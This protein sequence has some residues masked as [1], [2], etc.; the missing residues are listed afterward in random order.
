MNIFI[1]GEIVMKKSYLLRKSSF[2]LASVAV[3]TLFAGT[4]LVAA[5]ETAPS[6][7]AA[8]PAE[9]TTA[10]T[11]TPITS[12][13]TEIATKASTP[14]VAVENAQVGDVI[15]LEVNT[16]DPAIVAEESNADGTESTAT[17][18][19]TATVKTTTLAE[20]DA[21]PGVS[22]P[23]TTT[24]TATQTEETDQYVTTTTETVNK[25]TTV[26]VVREADVVNRQEIQSTSDIVFVIDKSA[27]MDSHINDVANNIEKFVRDLSAKNITAR[28]GL[29]DYE[30]NDNVTYHDFAGSKFTNDTEAF[31]AALRTIRT[32][33]GW[34]E[35]TTP[36]THIATSPDYTWGTGQNNRRFAF[37]VTDEDIDISRNSPSKETALQALQNAGISLTV[38]G[39]IDDKAD[40]DPLV[41]GTNGLYLDI[42]NDFADSL[43]TQ[44]SNLVVETVQEGRVYRIQTDVY[45]MI[46]TTHVVTKPQAETS[47]DPGQPTPI[48]PAQNY[49]VQGAVYQAPTPLTPTHS[50]LPMTGSNDSAG[51]IALGLISMAF[52]L[53]MARKTKNN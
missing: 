17:A 41:N 42:E 9:A 11:A 52:G 18:T 30:R 23:M 45:E 53:G 29:V 2:G 31:I 12:A 6:A 26:E 16:T 5:D 35:A 24:Q 47:A 48:V 34:E 19:A 38:V 20:R 28:L 1:K 21:Q 40:F 25:T 39:E 33:G 50:E 15:G 44:F 49:Y 10:S 4:G 7:T 3:A 13:A 43:N 36:L 37:L 14:V 22:Q 46:V 27:S 32:G 8:A 51:L